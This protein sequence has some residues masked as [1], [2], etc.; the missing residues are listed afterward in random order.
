MPTVLVVEDD[1][2]MRFIQLALDDATTAERRA[3]FADFVAHDVPDFDAWRRR[4][5]AQA[6]SL[7]PVEVRLVSN[8]EELAARLED[9]HAAVVESLQI[10]ASDIAR[11]RELRAVQKFGATLRNIDTAACADRGIRV[12]TLRRRANI[13]CAEHAF[14]L[15]FMLARRLHE[16]HGVISR[17]RLEAAGL[18]FRAFDRRHAPNGNWGRIPG[19]RSL[20]G[21]TLGVIGMGEIGR[22]IALRAAAFGMQVI[23]FQRS[24][25]SAADERALHTQYVALDDLLG[26]S[27]WIVPQLPAGPATRHFLD[28]ERLAKIKKGACIVNVARADLVE[29][30]ALID[31]LAAGRLGGF[32]LDPQYEAPGRDDD[33]LLRFANVILAPHL[34]GSPRWNAL[35]DCEELIAGLAR[36]L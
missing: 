33:E 27:D 13:A 9:A 3:A 34:G 26:R 6:S 32:A 20:Y 1:P 10:R 16:F 21:S 12:L 11:A 5:R 31:A 36:V 15:I 29:R 24:R 23:Y 19:L 22:E 25:L 8:Q 17:E 35:S 28:A 2:I 14:A 4:V 30:A 18:P 7:W